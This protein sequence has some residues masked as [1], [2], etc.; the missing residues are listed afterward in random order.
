MFINAYMQGNIFYK[1]TIF[2]PNQDIITIANFLKVLLIRLL[3]TLIKFQ[4]LSL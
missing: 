4:V 1:D 3:L 2:F